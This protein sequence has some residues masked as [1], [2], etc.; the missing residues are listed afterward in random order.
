MWSN[1]HCD[2]KALLLKLVVCLL[3]R[4]RA[5]LDLLCER[6]HRREHR[7][8]DQLTVHYFVLDLTHD[9]FVDRLQFDTLLFKH[10]QYKTVDN[11]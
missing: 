7:L 11:R 8:L 10:K 4:Q 2:D 1:V 9:L 6:P 5:D 3:D